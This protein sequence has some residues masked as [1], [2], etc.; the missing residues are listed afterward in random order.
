MSKSDGF[1]PTKLK[2]LRARLESS[3]VD[4]MDQAKK[5]EAQLKEVQARIVKLDRETARSEILKLRGRLQGEVERVS[6][7]L[8]FNTEKFRAELEKTRGRVQDTLKNVKAQ[9][10]AI[11]DAERLKRRG[12]SRSE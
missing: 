10:K 12:R 2:K 6:K 7:D 11:A 5:A 3:L 1:S 9:V 8:G 4:V